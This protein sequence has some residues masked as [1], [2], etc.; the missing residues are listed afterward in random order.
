[1]IRNKLIRDFFSREVVFEGIEREIEIVRDDVNKIIAVVGPRR[2]GKTH[3]FYYLFNKEKKPMYVNFEDVAF[4]H[5]T[6]EEFFEVIKMFSEMKYVP[7]TIFLDE[8]QNIENWSVLVRSLY[9]RGFRIYITGS[10]S[11]LLPSEISTEL[12]GRTLTYILLSFSFREF[13][14]AKGY[15]F[16]DVDLFEKRGELLRL[17]EEYLYYGG[18]PEVVYSSQK[19]KLL[20]QYYDEIFYKDFVE[21]HNIKSFEFGR[22]MFEFAFQNF[23]KEISIKKI[24]NAF[25]KK[26]SETTLYDYVYK[27]TDTLTVFFVERYSKSIYE[28]KK[29]PRKLY[30]CDTGLP[31]ILQFE[32]DKGRR[33]ENAVFLELKRRENTHPLQE[34]YY[35]K[36]K[37]GY[38][39]DFLTKEGIK[40]KELIQVCYANSYEDIPSREIRGLLHAKDELKLDDDTKLTI[41]TWDYEDEKEIK[42]WGKR[43]KIRFV[44]LWKWLLE[45]E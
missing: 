37:E 9:D 13:L 42:W 18:Y 24:K 41:I 2:V 8:V 35:Y 31:S 40:I 14:K 15:R 33:M 43:G 34:I 26:I 10:S 11:K 20:R 22:F 30:V 16:N 3:Y 4:K 36:T 6:I 25:G 17:L 5:I 12:R 23:S 19:L 44:P 38:E 45:I 39:V 27:I 7:E 29:W 28:R 32:E 1:M 21:R